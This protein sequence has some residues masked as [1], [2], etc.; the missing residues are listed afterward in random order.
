MVRRNLTS[1]TQILT[2]PECSVAGRGCPT[3]CE[4]TGRERAT[5]LPRRPPYRRMHPAAQLYRVRLSEGQAPAPA[6]NVPRPA[7]GPPSTRGP[8]RRSGRGKA[9]SGE[10]LVAGQVGIR[11]AP[12]RRRPH[13]PRAPHRQPGNRATGCVDG[14]GLGVGRLPIEMCQG[15]GTWG[16]GA[17]ASCCAHRLP[18]GVRRRR[19]LGTG[20]RSALQ[21]VISGPG[22]LVRP[23]CSTATGRPGCAVAR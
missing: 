4:A 23:E 5:R 16:A 14:Q 11:F 15:S 13:P 12:G 17:L 3:A 7:G 9:G 19:V 8:G 20:A 10:V 2:H 1:R 18:A 21:S 6:G 22:A